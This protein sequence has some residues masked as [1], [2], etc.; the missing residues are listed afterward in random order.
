VDRRTVALGIAAAVAVT[1]AVVVT[2]T[3]HSSESPRRKALAAY[4]TQV[5]AL[6]NRM[7]SRMTQSIVAYRD[8][9][10]GKTPAK[11]LVPKLTAAR[12]TLVV[13]GRRVRA[14]PAPAEAAKLKA[15]LVQLNAAE[16]GTAA[17]VESLSRFA[18][19]YAG[20][21]R[22]ARSAGADLSKALAAVTPP[23]THTIK[24][25]RKQIKKQQAAFAAAAGAAAAQQA[26]AIDAYDARIG[27]VERKLTSLD[28][29]AV[30]APG[31][32]SQLQTLRASRRAGA[33]L[34]A[35]L[36]KSV[37]TNVA[38]LGRKFTEAARIAGSVSSQ[39]AQI[40]AIKAYNGRVK[41]IGTLQ[42]RIQLELQRLQS[43]VR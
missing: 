24:G 28:P 4:I 26:D 23:K 34:S 32:R 31:Y 5:D 39:E 15:L 38:I 25:T 33:A 17:E 20:L 8:F 30:L 27:M 10:R 35:E 2:L 13:L 6:Q 3:N 9:S 22:R 29:P 36:R 19:P 21:L 42:G 7:Q 16:V 41:H 14:L 1:A 18:T 12:Q 40:A 37:R 43:Q 11:R